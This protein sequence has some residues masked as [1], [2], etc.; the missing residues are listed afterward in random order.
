MTPSVSDAGPSPTTMAAMLR[1]CRVI[2][3]CGAG[4][5]GKTTTSASLA[6]AAARMGRRVL[7]LTIDPSRRLA[8][9]LGVARNLRTPIPLPADRLRAA[10]IDPPGLLETWMLDAKLVADDSVRRIVGDSSAARLIMQNRVYQHATA[11]VAGMHEY[12][13][14]EALHGFVT[15]GRYDLVVL[16][17]PPSRNAL[18]FLDAPRRVAGFLDASIVRMFLPNENSVLNRTATMVLSRVLRMVFGAEL[19]AELTHFLSAFSDIFHSLNA[20]L[21]EIRTLLTRPD[22]AFLLVTTPSTAALTEAQFFRHRIAELG[23]P[24][25]GFV[26]NRSRACT[27]AMVF[28]DVSM[29]GEH[30]SD[31]ALQALAKLQ[32]LARV[33]QLQ[34]SADQ[35]LVAELA[36]KAGAGALVTAVPELS[37]GAD[38]MDTLLT[39][40]DWL[41][42]A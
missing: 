30:P 14:M 24:F 2:V 36:L 5:V 11:M 7:V 26:L 21:S 33:E 16:D 38:D 13:A 9:T 15:T 41:A 34:A 8:E 17:T 4:G 1:S 37:S 12:T 20:D 31:V 28:P 35:G 19:Q 10:G 6:L 39:V 27:D 29:L 42:R 3:C 23:M 32:A 40:S 18:D 25:R 22:V